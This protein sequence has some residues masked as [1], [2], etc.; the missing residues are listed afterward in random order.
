[1]SGRVLSDVRRGIFRGLTHTPITEGVGRGTMAG[2]YR[3]TG[4]GAAL[5]VVVAL[6]VLVMAEQRDDEASSDEI[7]P[8]EMWP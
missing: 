4:Q 8:W 7:A 2:K 5:R 6:E 3:A 1:M